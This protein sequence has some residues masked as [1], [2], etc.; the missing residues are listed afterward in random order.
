MRTIFI[1][2]AISFS[3]IMLTACHHYRGRY[4]TTT[5][6]ANDN[7]GS[8]EIKYSGKI[9]FT[10]D[11]AAIQSIS[12]DGFLSYRKN[13]IEIMAESDT[14]GHIMLELYNNGNKQALDDNG[15]KILAEAVKEMM[16][17]HKIHLRESEELH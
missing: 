11:S 15:K 7:N 3:A 10:S 1:L 5:I 16:A 13:E 9:S 4:Q 14:L 12:P 17:V 2:I 6:K 8:L